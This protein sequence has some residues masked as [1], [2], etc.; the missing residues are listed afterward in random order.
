[1]E[2]IGVCFE[3]HPPWSRVLIEKLMGPQLVKEFSRFY[4]TQ[5]FITA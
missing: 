1:M 2:L 4:G 5:R 3:I